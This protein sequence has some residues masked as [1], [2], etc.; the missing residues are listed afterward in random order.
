[1][2]TKDLV[3]D[4][5]AP[6]DGASDAGPAVTLWQNY[7]KNPANQ[8]ATLTIPANTFNI[9]SN[10]GLV[11]G[12]AT[13]ASLGSVFDMG[14]VTIRGAPGTKVSKFICQ[15]VNLIAPDIA[16]DA[17]VEN[18]SQNAGHIQLAFA[19]QSSVTLRTADAGNISYFSIGTWAVI[20]GIQT[21]GGNAPGYPPSAQRFE[22]HQITNIVGTTLYLNTPLRYSYANTWPKVPVQATGHGS[23]PGHG[24]AGRIYALASAWN[25]TIT[26]QN[27]EVLDTSYV[28]YEPS[29]RSVLLQN[30]QFN[31]ACRG[32][33]PS[34][35]QSFI[36]Q[37]CRLVGP[38]SIGL[39]VDKLIDYVEFNNCTGLVIA[40]NGG[41][42][43]QMVI[44]NGSHISILDGI[45]LNLRIDNSTI[46]SFHVHAGYGRSNSLAINNS[47][48][49]AASLPIQALTG[50]PPNGSNIGTSYTY[51]GS[52]FFRCGRLWAEAPQCCVP[53]YAYAMG[54]YPGGGFYTVKDGGGQVTFCIIDIYND[55]NYFYIQTNLTGPT[56]PQVTFGGNSVNVYVAFPYPPNGVSQ[57]NVTGVNIANLTD[58]GGAV[59]MQAPST[60]F[61]LPRAIRRAPSKSD[62]L[63]GG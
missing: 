5:G 22:Y 45:P 36:A 18:G 58:A 43:N 14:S 62:L 32:F 35:N 54:Y 38:T 9:N 2:G 57:S 20:T 21:N 33:G 7:A 63:D 48:I 40:S 29:T 49:T 3:A 19:G 59:F 8:P 16:G 1:M 51:L 60:C 11:Q 52:G 44:N 55:D 56:L 23:M 61:S 31:G 39:E 41:T 42:C 30:V 17:R 13:G 47:T 50:V 34:I 46:D 37:G 53:G 26:I 15:Y 4:F 10:P 25:N 6:T 27:I 24:G 12:D 28:Q